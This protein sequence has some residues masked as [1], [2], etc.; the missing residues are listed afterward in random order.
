MNG[1]LGQWKSFFFF[2]FKYN[3]SRSRRAL[4]LAFF[5]HSEPTLIFCY[6]TTAKGRRGGY[7]N[8]IKRVVYTI[9]K[10]VSDDIAKGPV[11]VF[12]FVIRA[13]RKKKRFR[14]KTILLGRVH[15]HV[16]FLY[17]LLHYITAKWWSYKAEWG[18][19]TSEGGTQRN[20]REYVD[21]SNYFKCMHNSISIRPIGKLNNT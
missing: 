5:L 20:A 18:G 1:H 2:L 10:N 8:I 21:K 12:S 3:F 19:E 13:P 16:H 6:T 11:D 7:M 15:N 17:N 14:K 9:D 4:R